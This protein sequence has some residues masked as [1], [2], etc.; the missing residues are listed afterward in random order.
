VRVAAKLPI[1]DATFKFAFPAWKE[2][3]VE[4]AIYRLPVHKWDVK[5]SL[6]HVKEMAIP[7]GYGI[8][9]VL[10][11]RKTMFITSHEKGHGLFFDTET[12]ATKNGPQLAKGVEFTGFQAS[13]DGRTI[14]Y[15]ENRLDRK[16][17]DHGGMLVLWDLKV[18]K[19]LARFEQSPSRASNPIAFSA[20]GRKLYVTE[21]W[22]IGKG[23]DQTETTVWDL[24]SR[25][26]VR[27]AHRRGT[28]VVVSPDRRVLAT[29]VFDYSD[30]KTTTKV[31][32]HDLDT[33]K[34]IEHLLDVNGAFYNLHFS[35]DGKLLLG[36]GQNDREIVVWDLAAKRVLRK[37]THEEAEGIHSVAISPD[38]K[39]LAVS[40]GG[41]GNAQ[42]LPGTIA[43]W[44]LMNGKRL[45]TL[46]GH[47]GAVWS[48]YFLSDRQLISYGFN[49]KLRFWNLERL[50]QATQ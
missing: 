24:Q 20:D 9:G 45:T 48:V 6:E 40:L 47:T 37:L 14:A 30:S 32:L 19:E 26:A 49:E 46:H 22:R 50:D 43:V 8:R 17:M 7:D 21:H 18:S 1:A 36:A 12:G 27:R 23:K 31:S 15:G 13:P 44:D 28:S 41:S 10:N 38:S 4:P 39:R 11:D 35:P 2:G 16:T 25:Q 29:G 33:N 42:K 34:L 5:P 3:M